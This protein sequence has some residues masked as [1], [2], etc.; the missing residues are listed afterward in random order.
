MQD[1]SP[2]SGGLGA[3]AQ[4]CAVTPVQL[5]LGS[6]TALCSCQA[7]NT[8]I[9][10]SSGA[11]GGCLKEKLLC[12]GS[13]GCPGLARTVPA[14]PGEGSAALGS[15]PAH[16]WLPHCGALSSS[17][18]GLQLRGRAGVLDSSSL[19]ALLPLLSLCLSSA[20]PACSRAEQ[21]GWLSILQWVE[22]GV[23]KCCHPPS[24]RN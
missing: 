7:L 15:V 8:L 23:M 18:S 12:S 16:S 5:E 17:C 24:C 4:R 19:Q 2:G 10:S 3:G 21:Q 6:S 14:G 9:T 1:V 13:P 20:I 11:G 22:E